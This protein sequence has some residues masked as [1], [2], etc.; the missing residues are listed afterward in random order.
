M[1]S[2]LIVSHAMELGGVERAL[3]GLLEYIDYSTYQVDLFLLRHQ[4]ELMQ[5]IPK[6]VNLLPE[7]PSY[8]CLA[9]PI[10]NVLKKG[11]FNIAYRRY[12]G[13]R[14][15]KRRVKE[16]NISS[17]NTVG[18]EYSHKYTEK[19]MPIISDNE[20]DLAISFLTPHYFVRDKVK[21]KKKIAWVHTDY[22][23]VKA[24]VESELKMWDGF[25][26]ISAVSDGVK[27]QFCDMFPSL[28][29][30]VCVIENILPERF[31][32]KQADESFDNVFKS[33]NI[34]ILSVGR[35]SYA[36]NFDSIPQILKHIQKE[37]PNA[38]WYLIGYGGDEKL[39][40]SAIRKYHMEN[41]VIILGKK[42][43]PYPYIKNCDLY[44]QPSRYEGKAVAVREAQMLGKPVVITNYATSKNQLNDGTDGMIVSMDP[45]GCAEG[46]VSL[47]KN[48][49]KMR[50]LSD[51]CGK[52]DFTNK[53]EILKI[54]KLMED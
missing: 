52:E 19:C 18:L 8:S 36:K 7:I 17:D 9:V 5:F 11:K 38:K 4:G 44:A 50:E 51:H 32:N 28:K 22:S 45:E 49:K 54:Y 3:L 37:L 26:W 47:L 15:A 39:I 20:Y 41:D 42:C 40:E 29:E 2:I 25:D 34:N 23:R 43:N 46:I 24:D 31:I 35:F 16:L 30:K 1:K 27:E 12:L 13:K 10:V 33:V 53:E 14:N 48:T 21:A 6:E